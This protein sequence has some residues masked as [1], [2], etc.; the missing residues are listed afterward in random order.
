MHHPADRAVRFVADR[1]G[2]FERIEVQL[3]SVRHEL[4]GDGVGRVAG[5]DQGGHRRGDGHRVLGRHPLQHGQ[6]GGRHQTGVAKGGGTAQ[7]H[8]AGVHST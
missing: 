5:V 7:G 3:A 2:A 1:I 8:G 4:A 6:V